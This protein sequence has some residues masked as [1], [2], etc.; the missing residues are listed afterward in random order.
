MRLTRADGIHVARLAGI[1]KKVTDHAD[2]ILTDTLSR[3]AS[4]GTKARRYTQILLVDD[5]MPDRSG[6]RVP[7][8]VVM[9]L[10]SLDTDTMTPMQ[11]LAKLAELKGLAGK[12][13]NTDLKGAGR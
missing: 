6:P 10:S 3:D 11:A 8:P 5:S 4:G 13:K 9:E 12:P 1:P 2:M 7:D